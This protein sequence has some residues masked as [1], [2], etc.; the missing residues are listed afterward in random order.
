MKAQHP[1]SS[2][3]IFQVLM[4]ESFARALKMVLLPLKKNEMTKTD[5]M[6]MNS[7]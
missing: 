3:K 4:P 7:V 1:A 6:M 2:R 5:I